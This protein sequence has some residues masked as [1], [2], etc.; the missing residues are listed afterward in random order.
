MEV[1]HVVCKADTVER[2]QKRIE[3]F[4]ERFVSDM[5]PHT[6]LL[7]HEEVYGAVFSAFGN[8]V[9]VW[10][11]CDTRDFNYMRASKHLLVIATQEYALLGENVICSW[12]AKGEPTP[13]LTESELNTILAGDRTRCR[14]EVREWFEQAKD[15]IASFL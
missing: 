4:W 12:G 10:A 6:S 5:R 1:L 3:D 7:T 8:T 15:D 9:F 11:V 2:E 13:L 14:L